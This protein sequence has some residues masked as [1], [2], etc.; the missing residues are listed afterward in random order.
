M[1]FFLSFQITIV[2]VERAVTLPANMPANTMSDD[3]VKQII[4]ESIKSHG[5]EGLRHFTINYLE[6]CRKRA[7]RAL[8]FELG[9]HM[10]DIISENLDEFYEMRVKHHYLDSKEAVLHGDENAHR[11]IAGDQAASTY[12]LCTQMHDMARNDGIA[13]KASG[14]H[15]GL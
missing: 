12:G 2:S 5:F 9:F 3:E 1:D 13:Q 6:D 7:D 15:N 14:H 10:H 8:D 11:Q 4:Y